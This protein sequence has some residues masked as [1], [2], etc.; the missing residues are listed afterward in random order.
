MGIVSVI[1]QGI[2]IVL[3]HEC[4]CVVSYSTWSAR[5]WT[6]DSFKAPGTVWL[7][8]EHSAKHRVDQEQEN[9]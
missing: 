7:A 4:M 3:T 2:Y 9:T 8:G 1:G 5:S 6:K